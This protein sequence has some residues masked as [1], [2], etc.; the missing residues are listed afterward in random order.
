MIYLLWSCLECEI[1]DEIKEE[2]RSFSLCLVP[3]YFKKVR[4]WKWSYAGDMLQV[5]RSRTADIDWSL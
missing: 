3:R 4:K 1:V 5:R 2:K